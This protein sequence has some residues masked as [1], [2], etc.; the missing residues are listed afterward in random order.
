MGLPLMNDLKS[1]AKRTLE[2]LLEGAVSLNRRDVVIMLANLGFNKRHGKGSH[3]IWQHPKLPGHI[4][5]KAQKGTDSIWGYQMNELRKAVNE[6]L[7]K[8]VPEVTKPTVIRMEKPKPM[9][10]VEEIKKPPSLPNKALWLSAYNFP[11][12][13]S[14][15]IYS[16]ETKEI[17]GPE[18]VKLLTDSGYKSSTGKEYRVDTL[19]DIKKNRPYKE[20]KQKQ[21]SEVNTTIT[22]RT[23]EDSPIIPM[24]TIR[25]DS[26]Q[27]AVPDANAFLQHFNSI[28]EENKTLK[29]ELDKERKKVQS[30]KDHLQHVRKICNEYI[31]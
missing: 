13:V 2:K 21:M 20:W 23:I 11:D 4:C 10:L 12:A 1:Q 7:D 19:A 30:L 29:I 26:P 8:E 3:I 18:L 31:C 14:E 28:I 25:P 24:Q 17:T 9:K 16:W 5:W 22:G 6:L 15:L 27:P